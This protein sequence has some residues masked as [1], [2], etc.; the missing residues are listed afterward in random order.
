MEVLEEEKN[1]L[2][3]EFNTINNSQYN[4][5]FKDIFKVDVFSNNET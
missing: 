2:I 1:R 5:Y 3:N 4:D